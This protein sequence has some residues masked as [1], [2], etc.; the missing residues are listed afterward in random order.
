[1]KTSKI[2]RNLQI[3]Q[4]MQFLGIPAIKY[5]ELKATYGGADKLHTALAKMLGA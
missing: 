4:A 3:M 1:M 5:S 2:T